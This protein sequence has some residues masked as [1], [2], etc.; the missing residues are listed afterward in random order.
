M[1][2][3]NKNKGICVVCF[4]VLCQINLWSQN[5]QKQIAVSDSIT[6]LLDND[7]I[8]EDAKEFRGS[9]PLMGSYRG[10]VFRNKESHV[11]SKI[12]LVFPEN[13][14]KIYCLDSTILK[15]SDLFGEYYFFGNCVVSKQG[16]LITDK[17]ESQKLAA[18][19]NIFKTALL[20][21]PLNKTH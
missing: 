1:K 16:F 21:Y 6:T 7:H 12:L 10:G 20:V 17:E 18:Y 5:V 14:V 13:G 15:I 8:Y 19:K 4:F 3:L 2:Y 11:I 9:S